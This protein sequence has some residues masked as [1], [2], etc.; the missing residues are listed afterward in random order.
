M[1]KNLSLFLLGSG[2]LVL[3]SCKEDTDGLAAPKSYPAI[4]ETFGSK[5]N[6][7]NLPNYESQTKPAYITKDNTGANPIKNE[8]ATLGRVLFYDTKLSVNNQISCASCHKQEFAFGDTAQLSVGFEGAKTLVHSMRLVNARFS[9]EAKFFWDERAASLEQ[10]T[11]QPIQDHLEMGYSGKPGYPNLDSLL[12]KLMAIDYY[13]E[14]TQLAFG[15]EQ[16]TELRLQ[17]ALAQFVRSLQSFDSKYDAGRSQ[18]AK[19]SEP[20]PNFT[21]QENRGKQLFMQIQGNSGTS[22]SGCHIPP[23][24]D[25]NLNSGNNGIIGVPSNPAAVDVNITRSPTLRDMVNNKGQLNGPLMHTGE[26]KTLRAVIDHY[27]NIII[28]D[29]NTNLDFHLR[30]PSGSGQ[31]MN[32]DETKKQAL[33]A[34]L[35]TLTGQAIYTAEKYSNPFPQ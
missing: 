17:M 1:F 29:R 2:L 12:Q 24:F 6:P 3:A 31:Q 4:A 32:L 7:T 9:Q 13:K 5:L 11:T 27:N 21:G 26:L 20:F 16:L 15:D 28:D 18:V 14:L 19:E 25:I 10:Q 8:V 22:C 23:E 30:A 35:K 33:I 34:F